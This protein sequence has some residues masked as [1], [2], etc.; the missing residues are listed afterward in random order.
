[1]IGGR[2]QPV[3]IEN[4]REY[5]RL[6]KRW[7]L[8]D[9]VINQATCFRSGVNDFIPARFLS[10][11]TPAELRYDICGNENVADWDETII[12][13]LFKLDGGKGSQEAMIAVAAI[14][15]EGGASLS[16]RFSNDSPVSR[17]GECLALP[18]LHI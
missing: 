12:R 4:V 14:G 15:G 17:Y 8:S 2:D 13:G 7:I 9:S 18:N 5:V 11:L 6:C 10:L 1:M 3:T 16:R